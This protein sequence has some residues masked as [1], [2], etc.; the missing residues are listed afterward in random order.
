MSEKRRF[1][2]FNVLM[3]AIGKTKGALKKMKI[4]NFC[5]EGVG[6][7]SHEAFDL[8]DDVEV[9]M[10]IP[11]DNIPIFFEGEVTWTGS[12]EKN[13]EARNEGGIKFK[14]I[15]N[16]DRGRILEFIYS[17]W[18]TPKDKQDIVTTDITK[19]NMEVT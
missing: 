19:N 14:K 17:R 16:K 9:E 5:R 2:R 1:I 18:I 7:L 8:G 11:G 3:G 6:I 10:M 15:S 12:S 13:N 4:N